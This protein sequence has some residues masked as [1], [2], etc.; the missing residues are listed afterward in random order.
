MRFFF[1]LFATSDKKMTLEQDQQP[2][3]L[4]KRIIHICKLTVL[5]SKIERDHTFN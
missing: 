5:Q 3:Y 4:H 1:I 2:R